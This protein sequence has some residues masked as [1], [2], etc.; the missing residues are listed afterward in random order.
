MFGSG[1]PLRA[2]LAGWK[3]KYYTFCWCPADWHGLFGFYKAKSRILTCN[4]ATLKCFHHTAI[5]DIH[6]LISVRL[7]KHNYS[8]CSSQWNAFRHVR[9]CAATIAVHHQVNSICI[10]IPNI[11]YRCT[12]HWNQDRVKVEVLYYFLLMSGW[13]TW[14]TRSSQS[15]I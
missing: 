5:V 3:W 11:R 7:R 9:A 2:R 4:F 14:L 10:W 13:L 15:K 12:D 1:S 6:A 8:P